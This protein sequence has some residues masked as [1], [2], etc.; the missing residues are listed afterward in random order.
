M[1]GS[2][3]RKPSGP[4]TYAA[5]GVDIQAAERALT[6]ARGA[7]EATH[8]PGVLAG[9]GGFAGL[10]DLGAGQVLAASADGVGTKL[11]VA[12]ALDRHD[13]V[14]VDLVAMVVDDLVVVDARP[15]LPNGDVYTTLVYSCRGSDVRTV[16]VD[17]RVAV[18]DG[19]LLTL[20]V[21]TVRAEAI[22]AR[23]ALLARASLT[24]LTDCRRP[25]A[26]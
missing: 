23:D 6:M 15:H 10:W 13:T 4:L 21:E 16:L 24:E 7:L 22:A 17:G 25:N 12:Q 26:M 19:R 11:L 18:E 14:G 8:G 5:S 20:D 2:G 3:G 9:I 1:S